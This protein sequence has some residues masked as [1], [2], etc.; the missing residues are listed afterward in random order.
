[1]ANES[2]KGPQLEYNVSGLFQ[3]QGYLTRRSVPLY[4][5]N[6][7]QDATD[8][9]V[10]GFLFT[11]PFQ[12]HKII[13]DCKNKQKSKPYER[14]FWAKGLGQFVGAT[15]IYVSLPQASWDTVKFAQKGDIRILT[16][17]IIKDYFTHNSNV[18]GIAD[19]EFYIDFFNNINKE[20][21][22][23]K[24][25]G[26]FWNSL[27]KLYLNEDPYVAINIAME[28]LL[29][30]GKNLSFSKER[31]LKNNYLFWKYICCEALV[32][33]G[34][35][36]LNICADTICLPSKSR[37]Q[38]ILSKLTYGDIDPSKINTILN[39]AKI[40]AN[41]MVK[42][43]IPKNALPKSTVVD[44][45]EISP[46]TYAQSIIGLVERAIQ[47]PEWYINLPQVLD[48][49]LFEF[50]VKNKEFSMDTFKTVFNTGFAE[51]KLKAAKNV[52][53]FARNICKINLKLIWDN[54]DT[55]MVKKNEQNIGE[56]LSIQN[57]EV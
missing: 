15:D 39:Y 4:Y 26:V 24:T 46:P 55:F 12:V 53:V 35:N 22:S 18:Y 45:G 33:I 27:K 31:G 3:N 49:I 30:G 42:A 43:T 8:I 56:E 1:M 17:D 34:L 51:E 21:K 11:P 44:F 40:A 50:A 19:D 57:S 10:V 6:N 37:E 32:L 5:G 38:H 2:G 16:S 14:I 54:S 28:L 23:D 41:E 7:N 52:L 48:F 9:D 47:N 29:N 20:I 25:L 36:I 13:C